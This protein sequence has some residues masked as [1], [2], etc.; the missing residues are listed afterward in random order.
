MTRA[1]RETP[2]FSRH[3]KLLREA[4]KTFKDFGI[5]GLGFRLSLSVIAETNPQADQPSLRPANPKT[6]F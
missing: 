5:Y 2:R 3:P 4:P 6:T 1:H